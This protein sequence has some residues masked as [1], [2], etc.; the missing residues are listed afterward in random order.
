MF[1]FLF[2]LV[3]FIGGQSYCVGLW[4]GH[5]YKEPF[6]QAAHACWSL[7]A[8]IGPFIIGRFLIELPQTY[9]GNKAVTASSVFDAADVTALMSYDHGSVGMFV[10]Q[11]Y[12][13]M[14]S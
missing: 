5:R 7:G 2:M 3:H 6:L 4:I 12:A 10:E 14:F 11:T 9:V 13:L 8:T 1:I